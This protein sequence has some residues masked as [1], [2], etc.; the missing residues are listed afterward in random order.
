MNR[1]SYT[2][3]EIKSNDIKKVFT[4]D[5]CIKTY[6]DGTLENVLFDNI[7]PNEV[8]N[9]DM[10][11]EVTIYTGTNNTLSNEIIKGLTVDLIKKFFEQL[12]KT[13]KELDNYLLDIDD[14]YLHKDF[15]FIDDEIKFIYLPN[16]KNDVCKQIKE[17]FKYILD[18]IDYTNRGLT[19][20]SFAIFQ[21]LESGKKL[22]EVKKFISSFDYISPIDKAKNRIEYDEV[23]DELSNIEN[24]DFP[25]ELENVEEEKSK[26]SIN[27]R[28]IFVGITT[29]IFVSLILAC[30]YFD[31]GDETMGMVIISYVIIMFIG[32]KFDSYL[33]FTHIRNKNAIK[34][35]NEDCNI[36]ENECT[37]IIN[38]GYNI[39][40][41]GRD[42]NITI[43][44]L[45][46]VIGSG[47]DTDYLL[48]RRYVSKKHMRVLEKNGNIYIEDLKSTNGTY[49][50][51]KKITDEVKIKTGDSLKIAK[52]TFTVI[53]TEREH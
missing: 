22:C 34:T 39:I 8:V 16:Y 50:N 48:N 24:E 47:D 4:Y 21:M 25:Y 33:K 45:P 51:G 7:L 19:T 18:R 53:Y 35:K 10:I 27:C 29:L 13:E 37:E 14:L 28:Y 11:R 36:E 15:I 23:Y 40:F 6:K 41:S 32:Y 38:N 49:L 2:Y 31:F 30:F 9:I 3:N 46:F 17:I 12:D 20:L 42:N 44:R 52:Y 43:D 5:G 26:K 1:H